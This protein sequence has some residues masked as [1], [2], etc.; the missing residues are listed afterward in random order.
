MLVWQLDSK[1]S[2]ISIRLIF[3]QIESQRFINYENV[4]L[5]LAGF[6]GRKPWHGMYVSY[7]T[8]SQM[9]TLGLSELED[10]HYQQKEYNTR[11]V[12]HGKAFSL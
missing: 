10:P 3:E 12:A 1:I 2:N 6:A 11:T 9:K 4:N 7:G 5:Q 8:V